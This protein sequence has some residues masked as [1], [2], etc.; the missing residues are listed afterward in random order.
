MQGRVDSFLSFYLENNILPVSQDIS[1]LRRHFQRREALFRSLGISPNLVRGASIIEFG[2]GSGHNAIYTASLYPKK[3]YLVEGNPLG[4]RKTRE[5]LSGFDIK[6]FEVFNSLFL[7]YFMEE[8]FD[9]VWAEGCIPGQSDPHSILK[10]LS[11]FS[12]PLGI[13]VCTTNNETSF[14]SE[15][16]R[17]L[18]LDSWFPQSLSS[19]ECGLNALRPLLSSHLG[20][21]RGMSRSVDDWILDNIIQP[22]QGRKLL[23]IPQV[24]SVLQ[25]EYDLYASSPKF[26]T[27]W[28]W[29]KEIV[30]EDRGFNENGLNCYY[31]SNLNLIDY[32]Y[33]FEPHSVE[34]GKALEDVC[35]QSWELM[36]Q[37]QNGDASKWQAMFDTMKDIASLVRE[38][39]PQTSLAILE[40]SQ[41]LQD[42]A[43]ADRELQHFPKWWGRG[44]QYLSL[45][46]RE[47]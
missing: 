26:I 46:R 45:I 34:F 5:L 20:N 23:S 30:G 9:I 14:L 28:R 6:N 42:G 39:A 7:D 8:R 18:I 43:P 32:R 3:Y 27:D 47:Y 4:V 35:A 11:L 38:M 16:A 15:I 36:C 21:L 29:Y 24:I 25:E 31:R 13:F 17:R 2:P 10:H 33:V 19:T 44:Q 12:A 37:I 22:M 1:D 40:A 41:W